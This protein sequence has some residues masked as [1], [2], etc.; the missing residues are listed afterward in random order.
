MR[1]VDGRSLTVGPDGFARLAG[2]GAPW[3]RSAGEALSVH[4]QLVE[5]G[6]LLGTNDGDDQ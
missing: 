4:W 3:L 6:F 1:L 2:A 5:A